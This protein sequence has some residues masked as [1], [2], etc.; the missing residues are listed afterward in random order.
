MILQK[1]LLVQPLGALTRPSGYMRTCYLE[2]IGLEY[3]AG[4]IETRGYAVVVVS[5]DVTEKQLELE[6]EQSHP[7]I[8]GFSVH[9]YVYETSLNLAQVAKKTAQRLGYRLITIFGGAH[10]T[11]FPELI[12]SQSSVDFVVIGEGEETLCE[13]VDCLVGDRDPELVKGLVFKRGGKVIS[14]C[15]RNRKRELDNMPWPKRYTKFLD[16]AKQYQIAYPPPGKQVRIAQVMYSRGCPFSCSF[17]SSENIWGHEVFWRSPQA[18]L[19]EIEYLVEE[20]GTNLIYFPDLTFNIS[21]EK[22]LYLCRE[23][24]RRKPPVHWWALFRADLLDKELLAALREAGCVKIS[25]G[26]ESP[27][28][29]LARKLKGAYEAQDVQIQ[30]NLIE[31]DNLGF[32]IKA[33]LMIGFPEETSEMI[34]GYKDSLFDLPI[35]ELRVTF[36]TPFPGT[37]FFNECIEKELIEKEPDWSKFTTEVPVLKHSTIANNEI[38]R[39][40]EELVTGFYLDQRYV[41]HVREK[42]ENFPYLRNSWL[43]YFYFLAEKDVFK[44]RQNELMKLIESLN[45]ISSEGILEPTLSISKIHGGRL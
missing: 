19:D 31:A 9:T 28:L 43:E 27:N 2:P 29:N 45:N 10:P 8:V 13:L 18:V 5:G 6:I 14:T 21:R 35:D 25:I 38:I 15:R 30:Q 16:I 42:L 1:I 12:A 20:Y 4:A 3:L 44:G 36:A 11:A 17:C 23:F 7:F 26:L 34:N 39:L 33:F 40:R 41:Q 24:H 37:K 32:I 22:V